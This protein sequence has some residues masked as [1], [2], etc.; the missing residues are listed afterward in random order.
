M[1]SYCLPCKKNTENTNKKMVKTRNDRL[2]ILS[3]CSICN[4]KKSRF[5]L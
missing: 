2:M 3:K 4:N 5:I 1:N